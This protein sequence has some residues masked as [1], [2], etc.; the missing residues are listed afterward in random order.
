[1]NRI[2]S[3]IYFI[4]KFFCWLHKT[5]TWIWPNHASHSNILKAEQNQQCGWC[6]RRP[7]HKNCWKTKHYYEKCYW[8]NAWTITYRWECRNTKHNFWWLLLHSPL[9][10]RLFKFWSAAEHSQHLI[11]HQRVKIL[12]SVHIYIYI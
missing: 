7:S 1:M 12:V 6:S 9:M 3:W 2:Q 5:P 11:Q 10:Q 4:M 8:Q